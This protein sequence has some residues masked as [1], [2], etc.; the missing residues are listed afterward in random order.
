MAIKSILNISVFRR[1]QIIIIRQGYDFI[2]NIRNKCNCIEL[3]G[4]H[5]II[6]VR[7]RF[8]MVIPW[9]TLSVK[10]TTT[11]KP[12]ITIQTL[13][14]TSLHVISPSEDRWKIIFNKFSTLILIDRNIYYVIKMLK[15]TDNRHIVMYK[16]NGTHTLC[17]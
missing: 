13:V 4:A 3:I 6:E 15:W 2:L 10:F 8:L 17:I 9:N 1:M 11:P 16:T 5:I 7:G 14:W 12:P